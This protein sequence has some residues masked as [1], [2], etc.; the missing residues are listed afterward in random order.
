[1]P[2]KNENKTNSITSSFI[3]E[4]D[5]KNVSPPSFKKR[6]HEGDINGD[7]DDFIVDDDYED[8]DDDFIVDDE[9]ERQ[10]RQRVVEKEYLRSLPVEKRRKI[11]ELENHLK[12]FFSKQVPIKYR[13]LDSSLDDKTKS[14]L[15][16]KWEQIN[17]TEE[18]SELSKMENWI[19]T[20]LKIP[21]EKSCSV[22]S[23]F[24]LSGNNTQIKEFLNHINQTLSRDI[25]GQNKAK[26]EVMEIFG[27]WSK[28]PVTPLPPIAL[29]GPPGSGKTSFALA[30]SKGLNLPF[31][32][33]SLGGLTDDTFL[34]GNSVTYIGSHPGAF[35]NS[36]IKS[37]CM[38]PFIFMDE[39][40]KIGGE[41]ISN[42]LMHVVDSTQNHKFHDKFIGDIDINMSNAFMVFS[43]ND[44]TLLNPILCDRLY[45]VHIDGYTDEEKCQ[46]AQEMIIPR[47]KQMIGFDNFE[48]PKRTIKT[49]NEEYCR[50]EVGMRGLI[51][52]LEKIVR[53]LNYNSIMNVNVNGQ[54]NKKKTLEHLTTHSNPLIIEPERAR[55]ILLDSYRPML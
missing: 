43:L 50:V 4:N 15:L 5:L 45:L 54:P 31:T 25:W 37:Q 35:V 42:V 17:R 27:Q 55:K 30:L 3:D 16:W 18:T 14:Y 8:D 49:I 12:G 23:N 10:E 44:I 2:R 32:M 22:A 20:I 6:K 39:L 47:L 33:M 51:R 36:L 24:H 13:I 11:E 9:N 52:C 28:N 34:L 40:D 38:N 26:Q 29:V 1:M 48:I 46:I 53:R 21:F 41:E 7:N 19:E